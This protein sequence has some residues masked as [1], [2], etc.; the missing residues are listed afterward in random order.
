MT[1]YTP[2][3]PEASQ[4]TLQAI[5]EFQT[6]MCQLT[7]M[8]VSNAGVYD[9]ASAAAEAILMAL[10]LSPK[11]REIVISDALHPHYQRVI[12]T[13]LRHQDV[14]F[15]AVPWN[16]EGR[17]EASILERDLASGAACVVVGYPNFFG[18]VEDL[19]SLARLAQA[20]EAILISVTTEPV[21][22]GLLKA[23]GALGADIAV[24]DGQ[25]LGLPMSYGGPAF[26]FFACRKSYVRSLPGRIV[27]ETVDR[28]GKRGFVLTLAAREQH[29]RRAKATS[30]ICTNQSLCTLAATVHLCLLGK[31]GFRN[32]AELNSD[33]AHSLFEQ[34]TATGVGRPLFSGPFFNEFAVEIENAGR[35]WKKLQEQKILAGL[36]LANEF[37]S[38]T[39]A[40]LL[41]ATEMNPPEEIDRLVRGFCA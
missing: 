17:I 13:Y 24:G 11:K 2:Y 39:N 12:R 4:G 19:E 9:G 20:R 26:G 18:I 27:G 35:L 8:D 3:Q 40:L 36:P 38:M 1:C 25:S 14:R 33:R 15:T 31:R 22:L 5:F 34:L 30:N 28:Q 6:L 29:I 21:A 37:P 32:L 7:G 41:C 23:P 10:K 16:Q